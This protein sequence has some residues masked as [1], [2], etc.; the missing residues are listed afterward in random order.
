MGLTTTSNPVSATTSDLQAAFCFSSVLNCPVYLYHS[1]CT[2]VKA[3]STFFIE[4]ASYTYTVANSL[5]ERVS[6][7]IFGSLSGL[8]VQSK[9]RYTQP[10]IDSLHQ[11]I[12]TQYPE[13]EKGQHGIEIKRKFDDQSV[14][15][16]GIEILNTQAELNPQDARWIVYFLPNAAIWEELYL[17]LV[18]IRDLTQ[19]NVICYNYRGCGKSCGD[20]TSAQDLIT[21]GIDTVR[22]LLQKVPPEQILLHGYSLGGAIAT[23]VA[24]YF[25]TQQ[26]PQKL[27]LC[28][29]RSFASLSQVIIEQFPP[30]VGRALAFVARQIGWSLNS[31]EALKDLKEQ[32]LIVM[33]NEDDQVIPAST[34]FIQAV[35]RAKE[36]G[37]LQYQKTHEI[38]MKTGLRNA[39]TR[40][41]NDDE[42]AQYGRAA[43]KVLKINQL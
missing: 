11:H 17:H 24:A 32:E 40:W 3:V 27:A 37:D 36:P 12:L 6:L 2:V 30:L 18:N 7:A 19:A 22:D 38:V 34:Q 20:I 41:W 14:E 43:C 16:N 31:E 21:D 26:H 1:A 13:N 8:I 35:N 10:Y 15:L 23:Q 39:H 9:S 42:K 33:S 29:E 28:N 5:K 4:A 25:A